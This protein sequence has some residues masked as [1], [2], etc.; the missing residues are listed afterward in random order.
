MHVDICSRAPRPLFLVVIALFLSAT[1]L[2]PAAEAG[3]YRGVMTGTVTLADAPA[4]VSVGDHLVVEYEFDEFAQ[5][6]EGL[7]GGLFDAEWI[8]VTIGGESATVVARPQI[9]WGGDLCCDG[10]PNLTVYDVSGELPNSFGI[11]APGFVTL[12][13]KPFESEDFSSLPTNLDF[14]DFMVDREFRMGAFP[15][16]HVV[17]ADLESLSFHLIPEPT[18]LA[19]LAAATLALIGRRRKIQD[20][21]V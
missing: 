5:G 18:S 3:F 13:S 17:R 20:F 1:I 9:N 16:G 19:M 11:T 4:T 14:D 10:N 8:L 21:P 2:T 12:L 7:H 6:D 15:I